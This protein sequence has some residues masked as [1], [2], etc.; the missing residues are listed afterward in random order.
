MVRSSIVYI[1]VLL[2]VIGVVLKMWQTG[3][4]VREDFVAIF[5]KRTFY[6]ESTAMHPINYTKC[7]GIPSSEDKVE[8]APFH[9]KSYY[10]VQF[11][12]GNIAYELQQEVNRLSGV[13]IASVL[14]TTHAD[15]KMDIH[16]LFPEFDKDRERVVPFALIAKNHRWY[17]LLLYNLYYNAGNNYCLNTG[18]YNQ[19]YGL[20]VRVIVKN[21]FFIKYIDW[22]ITPCGSSGGESPSPMVPKI[23]Q[24]DFYTHYIPN[25]RQFNLTP[26]PILC[27]MSQFD[28]IKYGCDSQ[29]VSPLGRF[30][31]L[32]EQSS[33]SFGVY[34]VVAGNP[35][36]SCF[37]GGF[38][39]KR[40]H[41]RI[42]VSSGVYATFKIESNYI[43]LIDYD[44]PIFKIVVNTVNVPIVLK[45]TDEGEI[46]IYDSKN[47]KIKTL[48]LDDFLSAIEGR[49]VEG[50]DMNMEA[51][52]ANL[53]EESRRQAEADARAIEAEEQ[54][55]KNAQ[56]DDY[57]KRVCPI[58][59]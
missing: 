39:A 4:R 42:P 48:G 58:G 7:V 23:K 24:N 28:T 45:L 35:Y 47:T 12:L 30:L 55:L 27:Y 5:T 18:F 32:L 29:L 1:I 57:N 50:I 10:N 54:R 16:L 19:C 44:K 14:I 43:V 21:Y 52:R 33:R 40:A 15:K 53:A 38:V 2:I 9:V 37:Y 34:R 20:P 25:P 13:K 6:M 46:E 41:W 36:E 51:L 3:D 59:A 22:Y 56:L 17:Y 11:T 26:Y 31:L 8:S 49:K